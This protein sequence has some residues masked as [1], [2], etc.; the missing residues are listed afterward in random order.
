MPL[1]QAI[2]SFQNWQRTAHQAGPVR[3]WTVPVPPQ[4]GHAEV[5]MQLCD[6][7]DGTVGGI[8][9]A[10]DGGFWASRLEELSGAFH[11]HLGQLAPATLTPAEGR[12]P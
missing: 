8:L 2:F 3:L 9:Q 11:R 10:P 6:L 12:R 4:P 5:Q 1:Y 7:D